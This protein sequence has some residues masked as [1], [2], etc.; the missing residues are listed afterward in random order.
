VAS[1]PA[2][3]LSK[4]DYVASVPA[5]LKMQPVDTHPIGVDRR[6]CVRT[7][8]VVISYL[9]FGDEISVPFSGINYPIR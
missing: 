1:V 9:R 8:L 3:L 7:V 6:I 2:E 4:P 5:E